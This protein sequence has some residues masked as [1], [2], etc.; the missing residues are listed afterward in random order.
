MLFV[1]LQKSSRAR[2]VKVLDDADQVTATG[3]R[4]ASPDPVQQH[5]E[6]QQRDGSAAP[7]NSN[8]EQQ[9]SQQ[10]QPVKKRVRFADNYDT[11]SDDDSRACKAVRRSS[12]ES[13]DWQ[14]SPGAEGG[15]PVFAGLND[16]VLDMMAVD[17]GMIHDDDA[18]VVK[19]RIVRRIGPRAQARKRMHK[20]TIRRRRPQRAP[21]N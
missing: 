5:M 18:P 19:R 9:H 15:L 6:Q 17:G 3:T 1:V 20:K 13:P 12:S 2:K 4:S 11:D 7:D 8:L 16:A 10:Q 14:G 21:L